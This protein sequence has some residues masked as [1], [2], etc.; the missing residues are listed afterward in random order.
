MYITAVTRTGAYRQ[1]KREK[2]RDSYKKRRIVG[3]TYTFKFG[4]LK[5]PSNVLPV[6]YI[7]H[8]MYSCLW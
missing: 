3:V 6:V 2:D 8:V 4:S 7:S 1:G 5:Y